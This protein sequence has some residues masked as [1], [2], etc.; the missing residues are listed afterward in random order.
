VVDETWG[1]VLVEG[2]V[3]HD[4]VSVV[5]M[6]RGDWRERRV[7]TRPLSE[8]E[9]LESIAGLSEETQE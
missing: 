6:A 9:I 5:L 1:I 8:S 2:P 4:T 7:V 3:G